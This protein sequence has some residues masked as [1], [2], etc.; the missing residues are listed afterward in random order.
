[1]SLTDLYYYAAEP[2]EPPVL[3]RSFGM[4]GAVT[5]AMA[6][7][8]MV[9]VEGVVPPRLRASLHRRPNIHV[10]L[11]ELTGSYRRQWQDELN[12]AGSAEMTIANE[13]DQSTLVQAGDIVR[14]EDDGYAVFAWL[15]REIERVQIAEAEEH[16]QVTH[17]SGVGLLGILGEAVVYPSNGLEM[18]P[19]EEDRHFS[20]QSNDYD[21]TWW[22]TAP[23]YPVEGGYNPGV[24][25]EHVIGLGPGSGMKAGIESWP[26]PGCPRLTAPG[27][28]YWLAPGGWCYLRRLVYLAPDDPTRQL[29]VYWAAD[30]EATV[31]FDGQ[32]QGATTGWE[33]SDAD[34]QRFEVEVSPGWHVMAVAVRNSEDGPMYSEAYGEWINPWFFMCDAH[35]M[36]PITAEIEGPSIFWTD[37][38]WKICAYPPS[39][40]G[41]TPGQVII[42]ALLEAQLSRGGLPG[43]HV[44]FTGDVDTAG[45]PWPYVT[46]IST[47]V[48]TDYLTFFLEI[49]ETYIDM[50]MDPGTF[51]LN[52]WVKDQKGLIVT[53]YGLA[54]VTDPLD[55]WSGNLGGLTY[56]KV[57]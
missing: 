24:E 14:F 7:V 8:P 3:D 31:Y 6:G 37:E 32:E 27:A 51:T 42:R 35:R 43:L 57:D 16:D 4:A 21:D 54:P 20:W 10:E 34:L 18:T 38:H 33:N 22:Q 15:V 40:P 11:A 28:T 39:P 50:S 41:W 5:G 44:S 30:D 25:H 19:V 26:Y 29:I 2:T 23:F 13:D 53:G 48:G 55:P 52:A 36:N 49:C 45:N 9:A 47:K 46:D 1:M 12:Q 17:F 56:K